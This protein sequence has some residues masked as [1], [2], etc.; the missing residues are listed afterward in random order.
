MSKNTNNETHIEIAL[1]LQAD[2]PNHLILIHSG[3][4]LRAFNQSAYVLFVLKKY[5]LLLKG[6]TTK[7]HLMAGMPAANYKKT[8]WPLVNEHQLAYVIYAKNKPL[9]VSENEPAPLFATLPDNIISQVIQD[10]LN[11]RKLKTAATAEQLANPETKDFIFKSK[12]VELDNQLLRDL[13][14]LPR[15]LRATWGENV[16]QTMKNIMRNTYLYGQ[17]DNKPQL[18]KQLSADID[19]LCHYLCQAQA[20]KL[21]KIAFSHRADLAVELGR[22]LGGLIRTPRAKS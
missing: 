6:P 4:F 19:L 22:L 10:L 9:V 12:A 2:Y 5:N 1:K 7:P 14:K 11:D 16:R 21:F 15:D 8:L 17:A 18:L 3:S 13:I 20:L